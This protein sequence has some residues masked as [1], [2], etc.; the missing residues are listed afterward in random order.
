MYCTVGCFHSFIIRTIDG[1][2]GRRVAVVYCDLLVTVNKDIILFRLRLSIRPVE[3]SWSIRPM[4]IR[5]GTMNFILCNSLLLIRSRSELIR[6]K[7]L[8]QETIYHGW[9]YCKLSSIFFGSWSDPRPS[10]PRRWPVIFWV[11]L[12]FFLSFLIIYNSSS[13]V[14]SSRDFSWILMSR[15]YTTAP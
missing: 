8:R 4:D 15:C 13:R 1:C 3:K 5:F 9:N 14:S 10:L 12:V 7:M 2:S 6:P 11:I